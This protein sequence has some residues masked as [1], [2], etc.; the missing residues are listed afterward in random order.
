MSCLLYGRNQI[1]HIYTFSS[2]C[3]SVIVCPVCLYI[4]LCLYLTCNTYH[5]V[6]I[7]I[8]II[9]IIIVRSYQARCAQIIIII[10]I[11]GL[12][13]YIQKSSEDCLS[14]Q[15]SLKLQHLCSRPGIDYPYFCNV[16]GT[17]S[18]LILFVL[19]ALVYPMYQSSIYCNPPP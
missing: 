10:I 13:S 9:I 2:A 6:I 4:C 5:L 14:I 19:C 3:P 7:I 17:Q 12:Q 1:L 16:G 15:A 11:I 18:I 8:L